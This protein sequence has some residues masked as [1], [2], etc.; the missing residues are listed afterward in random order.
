[1][2]ETGYYK[3]KIQRYSDKGYFWTVAFFFGGLWWLTGNNIG[4]E[5]QFIAE[6]NEE[7][8]TLPE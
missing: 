8:I 7:R 5:E 2:R 6:I 3:V 4:Y 1:M